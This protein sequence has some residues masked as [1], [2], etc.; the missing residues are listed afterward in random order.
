MGAVIA[1]DQGNAYVRTWGAVGRFLG[2]DDALLP[3]TESEA[4]TLAMRIGARQIR[5]TPEG[6][7]LSRHLLATVDN[8]FPVSGYAASLS[9]FFL[10]DTAFGASV[11][12][13]LGIPPPNWTQWLVRARAA[14]K[15][16]TLRWLDWFPGARTRRSFIARHMV[17]KLL[18]LGRP[19]ARAPF[20]I[21]ER[22]KLAWRL[23][24]Q[25]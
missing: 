24:A 25:G 15:R 11:A 3:E 1:A 4:T 19:D 9:H 13:V 17:Q 22:L 8:L 14:Q 2:V 20:E 7:E 10:S 5:K 12:D 23:G 16:V 18:L 6:E 21:P